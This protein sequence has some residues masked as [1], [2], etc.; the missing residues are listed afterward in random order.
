MDEGNHKNSTARTSHV[1][2]I[3]FIHSLIHA[4]Q[5]Q[6]P[7]RHFTFK[8][9][10]KWSYKQLYL[11]SGYLPWVKHKGKPTSRIFFFPKEAASM[12]QAR[13]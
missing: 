12:R 3:E 10:V 7:H 9:P 5:L 8:Q 4:H 2:F 6:T 11:S 13:I 1:V